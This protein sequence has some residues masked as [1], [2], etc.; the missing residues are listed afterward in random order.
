MMDVS[1]SVETGSS[2]KETVNKCME[3]THD[4]N[5]GETALLS[6][7]CCIR[8]AGSVKGIVLCGLWYAFKSAPFHIFS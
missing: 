3:E 2:G 1:S 7:K 6:N 8:I 4:E 5:G